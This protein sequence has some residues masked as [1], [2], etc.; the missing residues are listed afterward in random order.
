MEYNTNASQTTVRFNEPGNFF[1]T[2]LRSGN[3]GFYTVIENLR[4][5]TVHIY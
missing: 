3:I 5:H 1:K 2:Q 4:F